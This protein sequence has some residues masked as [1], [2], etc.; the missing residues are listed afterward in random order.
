MTDQR[1]PIDPKLAHAPQ[2]M[3]PEDVDQPGPK[4]GPESHRPKTEEQEPNPWLRE[5]ADAPDAADIED[6]SAQL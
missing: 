4:E 3:R 1:P 6:P 2:D 5:G